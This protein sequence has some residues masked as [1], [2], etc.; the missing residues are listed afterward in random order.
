MIGFARL[1][2][3]VLT[4]AAVAA[5]VPLTAIAASTAVEPAAGPPAV[6]PDGSPSAVHV[7]PEL[8]LGPESSRALQGAAMTDR[9]TASLVLDKK[10][11]YRALPDVPGA[12]QT[13]HVRN[14]NR[15]QV[16]GTYAVNDGGTVRLRGFLMRSRHLTRID[17]P[18]AVATVPLGINDHGQVVGSWVGP[19]ATVNPVTGEL[20]P[21]HGFRW[22]RGKFR[23]FD[24]PGSTSTAA[25][26]IN[27]RGEIVGNYTDGNDV[28]HGY[29]LAKGRVTTIDHPRATDAPNLTATRVVGIND[30]GQLVGSYGDD[31]GI[32][33]AWAWKRGR[34]ITIHPR[35]G[36]QS[37]AS[38]IDN[39]GRIVG[40]YIDP[41]LRSF[42]LERG[43]YTRIDVPNRCDTAAL[44]INDRGQILI[45][46]AG[47]TD[48]TT[49]PPAAALTTR[50]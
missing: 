20:N 8:S 5:L 2:L 45:A 33:R 24:I 39:H 32:I 21:V 11:D 30:R 15:G 35:F 40:R 1:R 47:T 28:Q 14:N 42:L 48:G 34:F 7:L 26:E 49:C 37:E 17:M 3:R 46:A 38:Q 13:T 44:D 25:Y 6:E 50:R 10:G 4:A 12:L 19:D 23:T 9:S 29:I 43:K 16:V 41:D 22:D 36:L 31:R 27:N 18:G